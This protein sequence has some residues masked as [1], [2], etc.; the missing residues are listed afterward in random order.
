MTG[1]AGEFV[2][3]WILEP[4]QR[5]DQGH[6]G[7]QAELGY[8][9]TKKFWRHGLAKEGAREL[10]RYG[11]QDLGLSRIFAETMSVNTVSRATMASMGIKYVRTFHQNFEE[12]IPGPEEGE[13][14]YATCIDEWLAVRGKRW[15]DALPATR[16]RC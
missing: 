15:L 8:R 5:R 4:P 3:W 9:L 14:E 16:L 10:I 1:R 13:V 12:A 2:G 7:G 11:F 6:V